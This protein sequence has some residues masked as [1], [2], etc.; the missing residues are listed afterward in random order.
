M[1]PVSVGPARYVE[2]L[3]NEVYRTFLCDT[4]WVRKGRNREFF[5][6]HWS[7]DFIARVVL[8][9]VCNCLQVEKGRNE[10]I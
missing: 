3:K 1:G 9:M 6:L 7:T 8:S 5:F 10:D 4:H 2:C